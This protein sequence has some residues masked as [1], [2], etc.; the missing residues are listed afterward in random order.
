MKNLVYLFIIL[1]LTACSPPQAVE[2]DLQAEGEKVMEASR[3]WAKSQSN[4]EYLS[5]WTEDALVAA[6]GQPTY[7]GHD[8]IRKMLESSAEIPGFEVNWEP[9]EVFLAKSGDLAYLIEN[10]YFAWT[11]SLGTQVKTFNKAVTI[12]KKQEDG[13]WKCVV[14]IFND[15]PALS[16]L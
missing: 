8:E 3:A 4:E 13:S 7:R 1:L 11:D 5:Y 12:W 15:D 10:N 14:D 2:I 6:P 16:S 9:K